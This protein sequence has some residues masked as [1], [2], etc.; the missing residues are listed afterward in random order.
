[1]GNTGSNRKMTLLTSALGES[2]MDI[3]QLLTFAVDNGARQVLI[4]AGSPPIL[5]KEGKLVFTKMDSLGSD[6]TRELVYSV[7]S[8]ADIEKLE[9]DR[10]LSFTFAVRQDSRCLGSAYFE[11]GS[12]AAVFRIAPSSV[13]LPTKLGL[14]SLVAEATEAPQGLIVVAAP[15]GHGKSTAIA[16]LVEFINSEREATILT[17]E[18]RIVHPCVNRKSIVTQ[19][20]VGRDTLSVLSALEAAAEQDPDVLVIDPMVGDE[21]IRRALA[22]AGRGHL[23]I[24]SMEADYV[25]EVVEQ[26]LAAGAAE[27]G[28]TVHRQLGAQLMLIVALRLLPREGA[29]G[30]VPA[31]ELLKVDADVAR[32]VAAGEL[33]A[34]GK[35]MA[36]PEETGT[37]TM[38]SFILKLRERGLVSDEVARR[39]MLDPDLLET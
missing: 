37:W 29:D 39:Y 24:A 15:P 10:E 22:F 6:D 11:R 12:L 25:L 23:M 7:L 16:S 3:T 27:H 32:L 36:E 35:R 17:I 28:R 1:M 2:L 5:F 18:K 33:K 38:D 21:V 20:Q 31:C 26:L 4:S 13:V 9:N 34:L 8:P 14:P 30:R 19:R